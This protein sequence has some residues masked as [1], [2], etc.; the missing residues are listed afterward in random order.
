MSAEDTRHDASG[1]VLRALAHYVLPLV[2]FLIVAFL[3]S[4]YLDLKDIID[5]Y[6]KSS[7]VHICAVCGKQVVVRRQF[8]L[9]WQSEDSSSSRRDGSRFVGKHRH[10]FIPTEHDQY[11]RV[12]PTYAEEIPMANHYVLRTLP[13]LEGTP[14][15]P[16]VVKALCDVDNYYAYVARDV[17]VFGTVHLLYR[18]HRPTGARLDEWW[19]EN[20]QYFEI[21][22]DPQNAVPRLRRI[23]SQLHPGAYGAR[24]TLD[25]HARYGVPTKGAWVKRS[26]K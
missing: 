18:S 11:L 6:P 10:I 12:F 7:S 3:V 25:Y 24:Q 26:A 22:H 17:L 8:G 4:A 21:E 15:L 14:Y 2:L 16:P 19:E 23:A 13:A 20:K 9:D 1:A 5:V